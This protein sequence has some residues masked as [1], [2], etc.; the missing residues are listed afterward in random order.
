MQ[1]SDGGGRD[2]LDYILTMLIIAAMISILVLSVTPA[3]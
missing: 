3:R 1:S 2:T